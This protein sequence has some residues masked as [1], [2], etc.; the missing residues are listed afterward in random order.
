MNGSTTSPGDYVY[1]G[2]PIVLDNRGTNTAAFNTSAFDTKSA[3]QFQYHIRTFSTTFPN[4][5][6]D[7]IND[8]SPS[9]SKR[10][11]IR[12]QM[13]LQLRLEA[14]NV[15]NHPTFSAPSTT[16]SSSG[17]GMITTQANRPRTLQLGARF[18]F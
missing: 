9:I 17:F 11:F 5:R 1:L 2:T 8:W 10:F 14:Y 18:V 7:G 13:N 12:E 4:L 16:A 15:L 6:Q 3:D